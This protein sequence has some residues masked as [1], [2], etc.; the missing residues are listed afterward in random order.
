MVNDLDYV[1]TYYPVSKKECSG[2]GNKNSIF[3][4]LFC[5]E[6]DLIYLVYVF[7]KFANC[8]DFLLIADGSKSHYVYIKDFKK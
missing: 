4:N 6:N 3:I 8:M 7:E 1:D 5:Y 2:I